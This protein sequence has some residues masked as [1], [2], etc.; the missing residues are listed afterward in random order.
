MP[1]ARTITDG[2]ITITVDILNS[3]LSRNEDDSYPPNLVMESN[4]RYGSMN[5]WI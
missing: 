3:I 5:N 1:V 4:L 2:V